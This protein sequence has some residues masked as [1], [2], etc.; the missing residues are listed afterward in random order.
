[1]VSTSDPRPAAMP[2]L[3]SR[4]S[5]FALGFILALI[6]FVGVFVLGR[7][8]SV[9]SA[10]T[11]VV[12]VAAKDI[13]AREVISSDA[14]ALGRLPTSSVPP[15][16]L[17]RISEV[18]GTVAQ[19]GILRGQAI[20]SNVVTSS[21]DQ[22]TDPAPAY[23]PIPQG[24]VAFTLPTNEQQ[25]VAGYI[26][27][28]DYIDIITTIST[29]V[30]GANPSKVVTGTVFRHVHV[31][32]VGPPTDAKKGGQQVG[33]SSSLTVVLREC[34]AKTLDWLIANSTLRYLLESYK[35][36][37]PAVTPPATSCSASEVVG[38]AQVDAQFQ[39][40]KS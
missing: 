21:P 17:S 6:A 26:G 12:V 10:G 25:G 28:G 24:D 34:D 15:G 16:A 37:S 36:Y 2:R 27:A 29:S 22:I 4:A 18:T 11:A 1:M 3:N 40:S 38:P 13:A 35:D 30:V 5:L 14:L 19:I 7:I 32:R 33:V 39:F 8:A 20:T 23:L 9:P 31:I